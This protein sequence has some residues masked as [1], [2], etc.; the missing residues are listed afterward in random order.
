MKYIFKLLM[1]M[2]GFI[3]STA[4]AQA[5]EYNIATTNSSLI[6]FTTHDLSEVDLYNL[7]SEYYGALIATFPIQ[8]NFEVL[9]QI[10]L[11]NGEVYTVKN[12]SLSGLSFDMPLPNSDELL[13]LEIESSQR[14]IAE[15]EIV[16]YAGHIKNEP[17]SRFVFSVDG[18]VINGQIA[19]DGV[20]YK[21]HRLNNRELTPVMSVINP[22]LMPRGIED[23]GVKKEKKSVIPFYKS[24]SSGGNARILF[25][26]ASNVIDP[27]PKISALISDHNNIMHTSGVN[28]NRYISSAGTQ[29]VNA[30]FSNPGV[31]KGKIIARMLYNSYEFVGLDSQMQAARADYAF[32]IVNGSAGPSA[33]AA[34]FPGLNGHI[35]GQVAGFLDVSRPYGMSADN[36]LGYAADHTGVHEIGHLLGGF[37]PSE[38]TTIDE[39]ILYDNPAPIEKW[40]SIMGSYQ[41]YSEGDCNFVAPNDDSCLRIPRFSNPNRN[42]WVTGDPLGSTQSDMVSYLDYSVPIAGNFEPN[43][44]PQPTSPTGFNVV[45]DQCYG[46]N[47]IYWNNVSN[48]YNYKLYRSY[49]SSFIDPKLIYS[50]S[51][52]STY[53]NVN[54]G[55]VY[56]KV[57]ACNDAGCSDYSIRQ[58]ASRVSYCL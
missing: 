5:P 34:G 9:K 27:L 21:L 48:A 22:R 18:D 47:Q 40:Q 43:P 7:N 51:F 41:M 42:Y 33:C 28:N 6:E 46:F 25:L 55:T 4:H 44:F 20:V 8:F 17:N 12:D 14:L 35:G 57:R 10:P 58:S 31:C 52:N 13:T 23:D 36:Y 1:L 39:G 15:S 50:G 24:G 2:S 37:H 11:E 3:Y 30:T 19:Y 26:Y 29:V 38:G 54:S 32:L 56:L 49:Y 16:T 45:S 53:I